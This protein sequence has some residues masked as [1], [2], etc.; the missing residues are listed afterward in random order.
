MTTLQQ[1]FD[2]ARLNDTIPWAQNVQVVHPYTGEELEVR[3]YQITGLHE[4]LASSNN[5]FGIYDTMGAGKSLVAYLYIAYHAGLGNKVLVVMP[6][7]LLEQ[8]K[9][10]FYG[11]LKGIPVWMDTYYGN[12]EE[13]EQQREKFKVDCPQVVCTSPEFFK[14]DWLK[15]HY[16]DFNVIVQD[17]AKWMSNPDTQ[18]FEATD[19]FMGGLSRFTPVLMSLIR[20]PL[21]PTSRPRIPCPVP[22][23]AQG[24]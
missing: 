2:D 6:P 14:Q 18:M 13:R 19:H 23:P 20:A 12:P 16:W 15:F 24:G 5:R 11:C 3:D 21:I 4:A 7:K 1:I 22:I 8:F 17:E 10:N 9:K